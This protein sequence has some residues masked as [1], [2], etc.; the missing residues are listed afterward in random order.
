MTPE[1]E[2]EAEKIIMDEVQLSRLTPQKKELCRVFLRKLIHFRDSSVGFWV[3]DKPKSV[4]EKR[5]F[6][7]LKF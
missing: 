3:T 4:E 1:Q 2:K 7:Q 5:L 6:F